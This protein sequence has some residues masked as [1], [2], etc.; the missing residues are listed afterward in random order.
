MLAR[1]LHLE[2]TGVESQIA[3]LQRVVA[4]THGNV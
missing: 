3:N 1:P 2:R 4:F